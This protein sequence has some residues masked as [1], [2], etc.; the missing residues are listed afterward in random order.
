MEGPAETREGQGELME[1]ECLGLRKVAET[2]RALVGK[3]G[4]LENWTW[5]LERR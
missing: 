1:L 4:G 5:V 2:K 3:K